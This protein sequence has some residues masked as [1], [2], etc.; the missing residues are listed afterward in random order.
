MELFNPP[1]RESLTLRQ[2][3]GRVLLITITLVTICIIVAL[4]LALVLYGYE[5][6]TQALSQVPHLA[7]GL[8]ILF[9]SIAVN[10]ICVLL[11]LQ[12][13]RLDQRLI[14]PPAPDRHD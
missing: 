1:L 10:L 6:G 14:H 11:L 7:N 13:K 4:V 12:I 2:K 5:G 9:S 3:I 8:E